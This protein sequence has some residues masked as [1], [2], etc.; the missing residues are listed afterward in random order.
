MDHIN[1]EAWQDIGLRFTLKKEL[2][3][4]LNALRLGTTTTGKFLIRHARQRDPVARL[5]AGILDLYIEH[6]GFAATGLFDLDDGSHGEVIT[7]S[8]RNLVTL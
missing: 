6:S 3:C 4:S 2:E 5:T 7:L 1:I 8:L